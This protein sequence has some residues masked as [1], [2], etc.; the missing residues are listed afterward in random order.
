MRQFRAATHAIR[1]G[2]ALVAVAIPA[3]PLTARQDIALK[4]RRV[5]ERAMISATRARR[6]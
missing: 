4:D 2:L 3:A 5:E 6:E 1:Y